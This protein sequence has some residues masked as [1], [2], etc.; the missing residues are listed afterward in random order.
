MDAGRALKAARR[1]AGMTQREL[2]DA[3]G[4][5]QPSIARIERGAS[6]PR[7]DTIQRLL[8]AAGRELESAP[9]LGT[10]IDRTQ[11]REL[12]SLTPSERGRAAEVAGR[13]LLKLLNDV[14]PL[15]RSRGA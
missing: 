5:P 7:F 4:V 1:R 15:D 11:I 8:Q 13:N 2:A 10:G 14:R 12:L 3:S 9:R 6:I